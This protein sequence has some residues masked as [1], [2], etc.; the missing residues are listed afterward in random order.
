MNIMIYIA[1][2]YE[3]YDL[4]VWSLSLSTILVDTVE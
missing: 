1:I 2:R 3:Y 4:W